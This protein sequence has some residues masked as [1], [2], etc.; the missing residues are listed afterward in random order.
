MSARSRAYPLR[1]RQMLSGFVELVKKYRYLLIVDTHKCK[2]AL[3]NEI[4]MMEGEE[5]F[6]IKGGKNNIL[7]M[8]V[9][10]VYPQ[11]KEA[12]VSLLQ[13]QNIFVFTNRNPVE[14]AYKL[15]SLEVEVSA[16]PGDVATDDIVLKEG[17]TGLAPGPV[18]SLFTANNI[19]TKIV[20]GTIHI[21]RDVVVARRGDVI[22]LNLAN[23]LAKL[24]VKPIKV[25]LNFKAALDLEKGIVITGDLLRPEKVDEY[26]EQLKK[27]VENMFKLTIELGIPTPEN[28][29]VLLARASL[30]A[31]RVSEEINYVT[32]ENVRLLVTKAETVARKV[33]TAAGLSE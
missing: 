7:R 1:K 16:S 26:K 33:A 31:V 24:G 28:L 27:A 22:S 6:K 25:R 5:G 23:L 19:P 4:R 30:Q 20:S 3:L 2:T 14:L 18:I 11:S 32:P 17:N 15:G 29:P 13:G 21:T 10:R 8:A 12:A 9:E